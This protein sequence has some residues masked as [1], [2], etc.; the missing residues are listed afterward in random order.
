MSRYALG[1]LGTKE[2]TLH[3]DR[4]GGLDAGRLAAGQLTDADNVRIL[5]GGALCALPTVLPVTLADS[6][7]LGGVYSLCSE[8]DADYETHVTPAWVYANIAPAATLG[9]TSL[10]ESSARLLVADIGMG[11]KVNGGYRNALGAFSEDGCTYVLY[12]AVYN[13]IDQRR[14]QDY[15]RYN[16]GTV[17]QFSASDADKGYYTAVGTLTQLWLD[18]ISGSTVES[19]LLEATFTERKRLSSTYAL[20]TIVQADGGEAHYVSID[21]LPQIGGAYSGRPDRVYIDIYPDLADYKAASAIAAGTRRVVRCFNRVEGEGDLGALG[22]HRLLL[23][24]MRILGEDGSLSAAVD[25]P[26]M[27]AAVQHFDRLFGISG[28]R[29][30]ASVSGNCADFTEGVDDLPPTAAWQTVT[31]DGGGFTAILSFDGKVVVFTEQSMLTVRG[32]ALPFT[33]SYE[34]AW[35]CPRAEAAIALGGWLYFVSEDD[36]LRWNGSRVESIGQGLP[37]GLDLAHACLGT[38]GGLVCLGAYGFDGMLLYDPQSGC[39][40]ARRSAVPDVFLGE[41]VLLANGRPWRTEDAP[42]IF[43]AD[44]TL[45]AAERRRITALTLTAHFGHDSYLEVYSAAGRLLWRHDSFLGGTTT[46]TLPVQALLCESEPLHLEG[47]GEVILY[48]L[49]ARYAPLRHYK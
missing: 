25:I 29:L 7:P 4:F 12:E 47:Y 32:S 6:A 9:Y 34:G 41:G 8:Y 48:A 20:A 31:P 43:S 46:L 3:I 37:R 42:S 14:V 45:G 44:V 19:R 5:T 35:G 2:K 10:L 49:S 23:P 36:V 1:A 24:D 11:G 13:L 28:S 26:R 18:R 38:H 15:T 40:T 33:L 30:Y 39:W 16:K 17:S 21:H 27:T 22:A